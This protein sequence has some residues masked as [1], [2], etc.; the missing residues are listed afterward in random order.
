MLGGTQR[1]HGT[2]D[3]SYDN[4]SVC[5]PETST[6]TMGPSVQWHGSINE[7]SSTVMSPVIATAAETSQEHETSHLRPAK[8]DSWRVEAGRGGG[9]RQ[10]C[11]GRLRWIK[12]EA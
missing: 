9:Q 2:V 10:P 6:G 3:M 8:K 11:S 5:I 4:N 1:D 7:G 12:V